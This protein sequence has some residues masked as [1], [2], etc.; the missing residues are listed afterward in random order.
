MFFLL[1]FCSFWTFHS[2]PDPPVSLCPAWF[3]SLD[4]WGEVHNL[5]WIMQ[6]HFISGPLI[7]PLLPFARTRQINQIMG[8]FPLPRLLS[9][10][11]PFWEPLASLVFGVSF[12]LSHIIW[13]IRRL[14]YFLII[15]RCKQWVILS[16][17]VKSFHLSGFRTSIRAVDSSLLTAASVFVS[18][19]FAAALSI[20]HTLS[21]ECSFFLL[22]SMKECLSPPSSSVRKGWKRKED[23]CCIDSRVRFRVC[24]G[25]S[26]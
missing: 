13:L 22:G 4:F 18:S 12:C 8:F 16:R 2:H 15:T 9:P 20:S 26:A 5:K 24:E 25:E 14:L 17:V 10:S 1:F 3:L 6:F 19:N 7:P 11:H 23:S 21:C